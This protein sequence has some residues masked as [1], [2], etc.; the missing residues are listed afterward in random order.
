MIVGDVKV[1]V[2]IGT[3]ATAAYALR[4]QRRRAW[5][6]LQMRGTNERRLVSHTLL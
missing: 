5:L 3:P 4:G 1:L 6:A 2:V